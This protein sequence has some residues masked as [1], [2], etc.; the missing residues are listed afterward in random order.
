MGIMFSVVHKRSQSKGDYYCVYEGGRLV[1]RTTVSTQAN[2]WLNPIDQTARLNR[3][4]GLNAAQPAG[5]GHPCVIDRRIRNRLHSRS[6]GAH[7]AEPGAYVDAN[8]EPARVRDGRRSGG[9]TDDGRRLAHEVGAKCGRRRQGQE[10]K[11][12]ELLHENLGAG[13]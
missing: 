3:K 12:D 8:V 7:I 11:R 10:R 5:S 6:R 9:L 4:T 13:A 1:F 2:E